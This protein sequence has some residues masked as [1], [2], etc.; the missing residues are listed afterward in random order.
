MLGIFPPFLILSHSFLCWLRFSKGRGTPLIRQSCHPCSQRPGSSHPSAAPTGPQF[1]GA[2]GRAHPGRH[3]H[4]S[5]QQVQQCHQVHQP[6]SAVQHLSLTFRMFE[7]LPLSRQGPVPR[8]HGHVVA[9]R[10]VHL[11]SL[12]LLPGRERVCGGERPGVLRTLLRA[13]LRSHLRPLPAEDSGGESR[14]R[15]DLLLCLRLLVLQSLP[16]LSLL[17]EVMNA[18]KQTWHVSCFTCVACQQPIRGNMFHMEDGQPYCE[19]GRAG[20]DLKG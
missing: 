2:A 17:Q 19:Q 20:T 13:V 4:P 14:D 18:L 9:P 1:L 6:R 7:S 10:G 16:L 5:V 11:C 15:R 12:P 3:P 8:G